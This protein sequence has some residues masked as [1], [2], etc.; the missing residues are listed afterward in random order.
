M[1]LGFIGGSNARKEEL[2]AAGS[3]LSAA[4]F[5]VQFRFLFSDSQ[6]A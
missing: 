5:C 4:S 2:P 3:D 1:S 6:G